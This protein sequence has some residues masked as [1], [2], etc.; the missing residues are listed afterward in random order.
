MVFLEGGNYL[1][2]VW[3]KQQ[4][5][6]LYDAVEITFSIT[7]PLLF[8]K[9]PSFMGTLFVSKLYRIKYCVTGLNKK[10]KGISVWH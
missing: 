5:I 2:M 9:I 10:E 1:A 6:K 3:I 8:C 4:K 7:V